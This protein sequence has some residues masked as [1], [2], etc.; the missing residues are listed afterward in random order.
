MASARVTAGVD[1]GGTKIQTVVLRGREVAGSARVLTP[2]SGVPG[3]VIDAIVGTI[4]TSLEQAQATAADLGGIGLGSPG[5]V[6]AEAGAVLRAINVPGFSDRVELGPLVSEALGGVPATIGNDVSVGVLGEYERGAGRPFK[7]LLGVWVGTGVGGGLILDGKIRARQERRRRVRPH[8]GQA[9]RTAVL[10]RKSRLRRGVRG[11]G[12]H[13][14]TGAKARQGRPQD[15][16]LPDHGEARP[17]PAHLGHLRR[18]AQE[19]RPHDHAADRGGDVGARPR[20]RLGPEPPRSRGDHHRRRP[21]RPARPAV[22]RPDRR[23]HDT[24]PLRPRT[25]P[26]RS[27]A[28]SSATSRARSAPPSS[29]A[30][31]ARRGAGPV[32]SRAGSRRRRR[33]ARR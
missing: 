31:D 22:R 14:E 17:Q 6:D 10:V 29:P 13:G 5:E 3:D 24:A 11:A 7:N 21:R 33:S 4:R 8:G 27:S 12:E 26:R 20:S 30:A 32:T 15:E 25:R 1:L 16:S 23:A 9:A 19:R 28:P 18:R 2:Q